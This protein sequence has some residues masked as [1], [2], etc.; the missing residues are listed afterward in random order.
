MQNEKDCMISPLFWPKNGNKVPN[1]MYTIVLFKTRL[2]KFHLAYIQ[3]ILELKMPL[4]LIPLT[5]LYFWL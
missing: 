3:I 5:L 2:T 4:L 1:R